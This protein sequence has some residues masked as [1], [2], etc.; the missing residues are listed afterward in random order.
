VESDFFWVRRLCAQ[1]L[2]IQMRIFFHFVFQ[3]FHL[4]LERI[5]KP[6]GL[7]ECNWIE[8]MDLCKHALFIKEKGKMDLSQN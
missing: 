1:A 7:E 4:S 8:V 5:R 2:E 6:E 3:L